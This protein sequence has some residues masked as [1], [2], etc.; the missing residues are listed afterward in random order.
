MCLNLSNVGNLGFNIRYMCLSMMLEL[1][2]RNNC[3]INCI[4]Y[5]KW[6]LGKIN[7][8]LLGMGN[9]GCLLCLG[10]SY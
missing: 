7:S 6:M 1:G 2:L 4:V 8:L 5:I 9:I 10:N 3:L